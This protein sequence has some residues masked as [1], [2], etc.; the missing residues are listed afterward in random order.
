MASTTETNKPEVTAR[1]RQDKEKLGRD[2]PVQHGESRALRGFRIILA[3]LVVSCLAL[4][5]I[6]WSQLL[7]GFP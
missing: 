7:R 1:A 4:A 3:L 6:V 5:A 2:Q